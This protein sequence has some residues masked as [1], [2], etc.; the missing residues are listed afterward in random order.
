MG[1]TGGMLVGEAKLREQ[2]WSSALIALT[3]TIAGCGS[4]R[5][6]EVRSLAGVYHRSSENLEIREDE[7][8]FR[9]GH[10]GCDTIGY[11]RGR[12][13][14]RGG[15]LVLLPAVGE[16]HFEWPFGQLVDRLDVLPAEDGGILV[17]FKGELQDWSQGGTCGVC[18]D[19]FGN[20]RLSFCE[21]PYLGP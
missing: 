5:T 13:E 20:P 15:I 11:G 18:D 8:S 16:Q 12:I 17:D 7:M 14:R 9:W 6:V 19:P 4:D 21:H 3:M 2:M 1:N 10:L